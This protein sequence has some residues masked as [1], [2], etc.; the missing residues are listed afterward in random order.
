MA[1]SKV[2]RDSTLVHVNYNQTWYRGNLQTQANVTRFDFARAEA[3]FNR[4]KP[5][6]LDATPFYVRERL[7]NSTPYVNTAGSFKR[8][9]TIQYVW[10]GTPVKVTETD[11]DG[12]FM[13]NKARHKISGANQDLGESL[14]ELDQTIKMIRKNL[15]KIGMIG[16]ALKNG[17]WSKLDSLIKG[18][19]PDS[20][21]KMKPGKRLASGYLEISFGWMPLL[22]SVH[23]AVEAY[24]KGILTRGSKVS[25]VSGQKR[26]DLSSGTIDPSN[27]GRASFSGTVKNP[28][29][30]TL[31]S[32][33]LINPVLMGWQRLPYSF[34]IDWFVPI[35]PILGSLTAEAGLS[36]VLQTYTNVKVKEAGNKHGWEYRQAEYWRIPMSGLPIGNPFGRPA[37]LSIGKLISA[38]ALLRQRFP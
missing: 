20:V 6:P 9:G 32:L 36:N 8:K 27:V 38:V 28:N 30:A 29:V 2:L 14:V 37:Q 12:L 17:E 19:T 10:G 7:D 31:N 22:S 34:V 5:K 24:G 4:R 25:A 3:V 23:T 33:G 11:F 16:D 21:K 1:T 35:G 13:L 26:L 18:Q 15:S